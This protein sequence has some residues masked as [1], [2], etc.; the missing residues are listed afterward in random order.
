MGPP[1]TLEDL[2]KWSEQA[3]REFRVTTPDEV[4]DFAF[5]GIRAGRF[6]LLPES[7]EVDQRIRERVEGVL[8]RRDPTLQLG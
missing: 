6:Y 3:G 5:D 8:A 2:R 7:E 4:A 1:P